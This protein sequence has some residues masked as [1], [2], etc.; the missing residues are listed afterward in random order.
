M[1]KMDDLA[2]QSFGLIMPIFLLWFD[3]VMIMYVCE[4]FDEVITWEH[5][6]MCYLAHLSPTCIFWAEQSPEGFDLSLVCVWPSSGCSDP[7]YFESALPDFVFAIWNK[8]A[9]LD[10]STRGESNLQG[11][12]DL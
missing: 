10:G 8:D 6:F 5:Y 7:Y 3:S 12:V 1:C 4:L 11:Y 9:P 2:H